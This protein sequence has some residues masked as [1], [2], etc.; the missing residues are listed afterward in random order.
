MS[1]V[2]WLSFLLLGIILVFAGCNTDNEK[3]DP[4]E[5]QSKNVNENTN[6]QASDSNKNHENRDG[7]ELAYNPPS[8]D[9]LDPEDQMTE[10]IVYGKEIFDETN[11]VLDRNVGNQLSC[12]SC[13]ANGGLTQS[14]SMVGV[15]TQF[16]QYRPRE[17][18]VFTIEDRINGCMVRSMNGEKIPSDSE[19]MRALVS[20]LTYISE[21]IEVGEDIPWRMLNTMKEI[22]E[23]SVDSGER[24]YTEKSCIACHGQNGEGTGPNTGPALWGDNSFNDGAGMNRMSK[25]SGYVLNNM[26]LGDATLTDQE[27]ADLAAYILSHERPEWEGH[28]TDWPKGGRP[29]DII[30]KDRRE[31]IREGTFDWAEIDNV[32]QPD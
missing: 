14:S 15:T 1:K 8:M 16:P 4:E 21:G 19:E 7:N 6:K 26:P 10:Y 29:T 30:T 3:K 24:L 18:V 25:M 20:Y 2:K 12:T 17:G 22:P 13:H 31:K 27:A 5:N 11:T 9:D 32:I 23:P 28:E